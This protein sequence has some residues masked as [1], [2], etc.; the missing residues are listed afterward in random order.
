MRKTI[1][2][3]RSLLIHVRGKALE[4]IAVRCRMMA[5]ELA[6]QA[7]QYDQIVG[8]SQAEIYRLQANNLV[9]DVEGD[10]TAI[11]F[12]EAYFGT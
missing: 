3:G 10:A 11:L 8:R 6:D 4:M 9:D 1:A 2:K 5:S 7:E 12:F